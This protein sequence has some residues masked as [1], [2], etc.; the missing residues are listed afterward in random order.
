MPVDP[1]LQEVITLGYAS[2]AVAQAKI[3][4]SVVEAA[5]D[6]AFIEWEVCQE[7]SSSSSSQSSQSSL[8]SSSSSS[9]TVGGS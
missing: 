4:L 3:N 2:I 7:S 8:N 5:Y 9:S 1:C 6:A